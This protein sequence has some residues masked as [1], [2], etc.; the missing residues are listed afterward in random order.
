MKRQ[1]AVWIVAAFI[2]TA[3]WLAAASAE[4]RRIDVYYDDTFR[5]NGQDGYPRRD[6]IAG[7]QATLREWEQHSLQGQ[8]IFDWAGEVNQSM[9]PPAN[10]NTILIYW[11]PNIDITLCGATCRFSLPTCLDG[12]AVGRIRLS[13]WR[14][15]TIVENG[16]TVYTSN[17]Q[18]NPRWVPSLDQPACSLRATLAHELG[19]LLMNNSGHPNNSVLRNPVNGLT[20]RHLWQQDLIQDW[21]LFNSHSRGLMMEAVVQSSTISTAEVSHWIPTDNIVMTPAALSMGDGEG[22]IHNYAMAYGGLNTA[23]GRNGI[24]FGRGDGRTWTFRRELPCSASGDCS[25]H[26]MTTRQPC[27]ANSEDGNHYVI[28][29]ADVAQLPASSVPG[30]AWQDGARGIFFAESHDRGATWSSAAPIPGAFTRSGVSCSVNPVQHEVVL[31]YSGAGEDAIW[32]SRR[33]TTAPSQWTW[34][35]P[36]SLE[37]D[38][39]RTA[40]VPY[41]VF[42][43]FNPVY[44]RL[45]W[46]DDLSLTVETATLQFNGSGYSIGSRIPIQ[47]STFDAFTTAELLRSSP[48]VEFEGTA[49]LG[50]SLNSFLR[51][52][53]S[54]WHSNIDTPAPFQII[55]SATDSVYNAPIRRYTGSASNRT[56]QERAFLAT[57]IA[58][59]NN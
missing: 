29:W 55:S 16:V 47:D 48:V 21:T 18:N 58:G 38:A 6:V 49:I 3:W 9:W 23:L 46:F 41:V 52:Q 15:V 14:N 2:A 24:F 22:E 53:T 40:D 30:Q 36:L 4:A 13:P 32:L 19:H 10:S 54:L 45:A 37:S 34:P 43:Q 59:P 33:S 8:I 26:Q 50:L 17:N 31:A 7:I 42:D 11:D 57:T 25:N 27:V 39:P 1:A 51:E 56:F 35:Q 12:P 5:P 44:G 28:A 20:G